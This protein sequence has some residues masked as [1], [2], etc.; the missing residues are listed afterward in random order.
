MMFMRLAWLWI[1]VVMVGVIL[2]LLYADVM[3]PT[4]Q[5]TMAQ[6]RIYAYRD[7]QSTGI[8]LQA[9]ET[10]AIYATG[11]WLYTPGEWHGA[12][13]HKRYPAPTFYPLSGTPGGVLL[14]RVGEKGSPQWVGR[15]GRVY[16]SE[17]GMLYLRINDDILTDNQG[18]LNVTIEVIAAPEPY[19]E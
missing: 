19:G 12:E 4:H 16:T 17:P 5:E 2:Y 18:S 13:G 6:T 14:G 9:G 8:R 3:T 10:A 1:L 15:R 7:W 11:E